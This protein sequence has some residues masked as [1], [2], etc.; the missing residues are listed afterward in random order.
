M[1]IIATQADGRIGMER[2]IANRNS[3]CFTKAGKSFGGWKT[4]ADN[5]GENW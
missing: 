4:E 1:D 2:K 5:D 3:N